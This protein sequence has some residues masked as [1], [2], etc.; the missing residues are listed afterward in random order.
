MNG[1]EIEFSQDGDLGDIVFLSHSVTEVNYDRYNK[2]PKPYFPHLLRNSLEDHGLEAFNPRGQ[3]L[4][5]ID[6]VGRLLGLMLL[7]VDPDDTFVND[8]YPTNE[9]RYF[10]RQWRESAQT[11]FSLGPIPE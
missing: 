11:L 8:V 5:S 1:V 9:A 2:A 3:P 6:D 10:L 7:I 4:R